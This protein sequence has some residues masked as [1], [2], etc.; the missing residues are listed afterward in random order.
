MKSWN[1]V[2]LNEKLNTDQTIEN[3]LQLKNKILIFNDD[4]IKFSVI[5]TYLNIFFKFTD[6]DHQRVDEKYVETYKFFLKVLIQPLFKHFELI[7]DYEIQRAVFWFCF[8]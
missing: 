7:S 8:K 4:V 6:K 5:H 3:L 1:N 2:K